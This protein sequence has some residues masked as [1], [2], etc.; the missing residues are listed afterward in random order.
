MVSNSICIP[1]INIPAQIATL[2]I[3]NVICIKI[4]YCVFWTKLSSIHCDVFIINVY[5]YI[6]KNSVTIVLLI[7]SEHRFT[8]L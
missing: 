4:M 5:I 3:R 7:L 1:I 2:I 8:C 6:N